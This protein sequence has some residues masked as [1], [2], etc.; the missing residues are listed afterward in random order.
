M[1]SENY[2]DT[3][4][5]N[6]D[7]VRQNYLNLRNIYKL[8]SYNT[9][10]PYD[11]LINKNNTINSEYL[12]DYVHDFTKYDL[13]N[14]NFVETT[15]PKL[16]ENKILKN[17]KNY[18]IRKLNSLSPND[19]IPKYDNN[20]L[21]ND[22]YNEKDIK[23][24]LDKFKYRNMDYS[25]LQYMSNRGPDNSECGFHD[26]APPPDFS[27]K[28]YKTSEKTRVYND[29]EF[30][31]A[32]HLNTLN[33]KSHYKSKTQKE[34]MSNK[35]IFNYMTLSD[36]VFPHPIESSVYTTSDNFYAGSSNLISLV[37]LPLER[38]FSEYY[39]PTSKPTTTNNTIYYLSDTKLPYHKELMSNNK[40]SIIYNDAHL[41]NTIKYALYDILHNDLNDTRLIQNRQSKIPHNLQTLNL[42]QIDNYK[43][44]LKDN[45][46]YK[47][48]KKNP[49]YNQVKDIV[50]QYLYYNPDLKYKNIDS[51]NLLN[52]KSLHI[53]NTSNIKNNTKIYNIIKEEY[54]NLKD[55]KFY[56]TPNYF[57]KTPSFKSSF[58]TSKL[59]SSDNNKFNYIEYM[60]NNDFKSNNIMHLTDNNINRNKT[61]DES[62]Y[63]ESFDTNDNIDLFT[64]TYYHPN[65]S[66][67]HNYINNT[68]NDISFGSFS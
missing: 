7:Y 62:V 16:Y 37:N 56:N 44:G 61:I 17:S 21:L 54:N 9:I 43:H 19:D 33:I 3:D 60:N 64:N 47:F 40:N 8:F 5:N 4:I 18:S 10:D 26:W 2:I 68:S 24:D 50:A 15:V 34:N 35:K 39:K 49:I 53:N 38:S 57:N 11:K 29:I 63:D 58:D 13:Q 12:D 30:H 55:N 36:I 1:N 67:S 25:F 66:Y 32:D 22:K 27:E 65:N 45:K 46:D 51:I 28:K 41:R 20:N 6:F 42:N 52:N 14:C 23:Y 48:I 59:Q 31:N